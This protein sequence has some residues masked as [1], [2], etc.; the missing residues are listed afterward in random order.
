M[1]CCNRGCRKS[2]VITVILERNY[3]Q[4]S[5]PDGDTVF[6]I[7]VTVTH[8]TVDQVTVPPLRLL[9]SLSVLLSVTDAKLVQ[10]RT[11]TVRNARLVV[12]D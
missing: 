4:L 7:F 1:T 3:V 11:V 10:S 6:N 12:E 5:L 9:L 8:I 2:R